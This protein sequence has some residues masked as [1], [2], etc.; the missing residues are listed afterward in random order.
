MGSMAVNAK[1]MG[2]FSGRF[3]T[4]NESWDMDFCLLALK[5]MVIAVVENGFKV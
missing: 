3:Q 2:P 5:P 4:R 1:F